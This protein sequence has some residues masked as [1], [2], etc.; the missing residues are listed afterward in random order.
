MVSMQGRGLHGHHDHFG[1]WEF[2]QPDCGNGTGH[3]KAHVEEARHPRVVFPVEFL[4]KLASQ[5]DREAAE[6]TASVKIPMMAV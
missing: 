6:L 2:D 5:L 3:E 1:G 4:L